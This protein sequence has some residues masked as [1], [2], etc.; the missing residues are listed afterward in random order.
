[1]VAY[2]F[3]RPG[4][5]I[6]IFY[7][8]AHL[9]QVHRLRFRSM[10]TKMRVLPSS[11]LVPIPDQVPCSLFSVQDQ[12]PSQPSLIPSQSVQV[13]SYLG[14][15][16]TD[17]SQSAAAA[18][19]PLL[20][21]AMPFCSPNVSASWPSGAFNYHKGVGLQGHR[22]ALAT[23]LAQEATRCIPR[24]AA[25]RCGFYSSCRQRV[26]QPR[27]HVWSAPQGA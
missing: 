17:W 26:V 15:R 8:L 23:E 11:D 9:R 20:V 18:L 16:V 21:R 24:W 27:A 6:L 5:L 2:S 4:S 25:W 22:Q 19:D 1:M 7:C 14:F 10:L 3:R 12:I 13:S